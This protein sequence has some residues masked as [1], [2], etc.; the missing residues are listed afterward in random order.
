VEE[1]LFATGNRH[2]LEELGRVLRECGLVPRTVDVAKLE[3]QSDDI[4]VVA[5]YAAVHAY[6]V[7]GRPVLVEDAG[8]FVNALGGFPGPYSSYVYKTIGLNGLLKLLEG[9]R[10][11]TAV[12]RSAL[13]YAGPWG[14]VVFKGEVRGR[15]AEEPRGSAGFGF[16]P[17][18]IPEGVERTFAEMST[19]EKNRISHRAR[20]ARK[21]CDWLRGGRKPL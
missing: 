16:D 9:V 6:S 18:F 20:A 5:A 14:V 13:A 21:F 1:V 12:F 17:V 2:K 19:E 7:L 3:V 11:R 4:G 10:E 8:L 15:I